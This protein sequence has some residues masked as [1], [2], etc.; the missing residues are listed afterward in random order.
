MKTSPNTIA[1]RPVTLENFEEV[2][3]LAVTGAQEDFVAGNLY[4]IAES[5]FHPSYQ[6]R[7]IY[8]GDEVVG[9]M[10]Y[11]SLAHTG[12]HGEYDIFRFMVDQRWQGE[13]VG[14]DA[15]RLCLDEIRNCGDAR[16]ITIC[17]VPDNPVARDF[18]AGFGFVEV[19]LDEEEE[20]M[21]AEIRIPVP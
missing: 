8:R 2:T 1:L 4:S 9:F 19:G 12:K 20:E 5:K 21:I 17:Y 15:M 6:P 18:Y 14:R 3:D 16:R 11:E 7:C 13:G 10:M